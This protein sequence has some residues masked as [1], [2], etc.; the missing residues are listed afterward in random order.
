MPGR[1]DDIDTGTGVFDSAVLGQNG[2]ATLFLEI[3]ASITRSATAWWAR[4]VPA[5]CSN[6]ST[7]VV[8]PWSTWAM[9]AILR[10]EGAAAGSTAAGFTV[11]FMRINLL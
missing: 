8:L 4:K 7:K 11:V 3:V 1:V 6:W 10:I 2:D 5:C 9:I